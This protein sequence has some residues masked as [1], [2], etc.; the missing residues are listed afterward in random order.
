LDVKGRITTLEGRDVTQGLNVVH[1][2]S[3]PSF[4]LWYQTT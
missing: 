1:Q 4:M 2:W 3:K